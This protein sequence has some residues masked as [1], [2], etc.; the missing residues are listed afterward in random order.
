MKNMFVFL[1]IGLIVLC[2]STIKPEELSQQSSPVLIN[3]DEPTIQELAASES[4]ETVAH[5][6]IASLSSILVTMFGVIIRSQEDS[7]GNILLSIGLPGCLFSAYAL[8]KVRQCIDHKPEEQKRKIEENF[9]NLI[10]HEP[11]Y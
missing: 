4:A 6:L 11:D 8:H 5:L 9:N 1:A 3:Q 7:C 10:G 2:H